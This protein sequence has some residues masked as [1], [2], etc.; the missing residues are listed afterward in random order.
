MLEK[1]QH[2]ISCHLHLSQRRRQ[3]MRRKPAQNMDHKTILVN[4]G[5]HGVNQVVRL[6]KTAIDSVESSGLAAV[7]GE[8]TGRILVDQLLPPLHPVLQDNEPSVVLLALLLG[9][10]VPDLGRLAAGAA[11]GLAAAAG[12]AGGLPAAVDA[13]CAGG[14]RA[15]GLRAGGL[16]AAGLRAAAAAG[17]AAAGLPAG[18]PTGASAARGAA[19]VGLAVAGLPAGLPAAAAA[20]LPAGLAAGAGA[21]AAPAGA[22]RPASP[23]VRSRAAPAVCCCL[24]RRP[25]HRR[26][27]RLGSRSGPHDHPNY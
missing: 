9:G 23:Q 4:A 12:A 27:R 16:R 19:A 10:V 1:G 17:A 7:E 13:G 8:N 22:V 6:I 20:G 18:L 26:P 21:G 25:L 15:G 14:L 11:A 24:A 2:I 5:H 3:C